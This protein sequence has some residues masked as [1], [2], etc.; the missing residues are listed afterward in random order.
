VTSPDIVS[1]IVTKDYRGKRALDVLITLVTSPFWV[2][3]GIACGA[4]VR[5]D[6]PGPIFFRQKRVGRSGTT[7]EVVKF[8][9]MIHDAQSNP[10]I[11]D[12]HRITRFGR[13]LRRLSLDEL[14]QLLNVLRGEMSLVGPRPTLE[15]QVE[16]QDERQ[17]R[18]LW[19]RPGITGLAQLNGRNNISWAARIEWD[20]EYVQRQSPWLDIKLMLLTPLTVF[21]GRGISG[22]PTDDPLV[23]DPPP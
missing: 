2:P 21:T 20:L 4:L 1:P 16:R 9:S 8:R 22:H 11:P 18:R 14:P 17:R 15:Y 12:Q 5:L 3:I 23:V 13:V 6:S 7:F 19:V 10:V